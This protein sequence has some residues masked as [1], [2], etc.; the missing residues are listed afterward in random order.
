MNSPCLF[1]R[2][3]Q[4]EIPSRKVYEDERFFVFEDIQP[5]APVHVLFIP[6]KHVENVAGLCPEDGALTGDLMLLMSRLASEK[7]WKSFRVVSNSGAEA[8]QSVFHLHFHLLSGRP[9]TWPPG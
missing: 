5:Q 2:I 8:Q 6:K 3:V 4:G 9:M 1:C 7:G